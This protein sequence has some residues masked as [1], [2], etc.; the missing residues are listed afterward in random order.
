[1]IPFG[2]VFGAAL[3]LSACHEIVLDDSSAYRLSIGG[4]Q[5]DVGTVGDLDVTEAV[6]VRAHDA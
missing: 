3:P 5:D 4:P 2:L 1:V 6:V